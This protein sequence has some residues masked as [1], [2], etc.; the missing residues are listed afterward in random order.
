[1]TK[2]EIIASVLKELKSLATEE[3][4]RSSEYVEDERD[5]IKHLQAVMR[6]AQLGADIRTCAD[7][8]DLK[9]EC[10]DTCHRFG[11][12]REMSPMVELKSGGYAW[13]CCAI[14]LALGREISVKLRRRDRR[15]GSAGYKP[16]AEFFGGK[17]IDDGK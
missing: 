7:F 3:G 5:V 4:M 10:C 2:G 17:Q 8:L 16:F 9:V 11:F 12:P 6:E 14:E 1:M 13:I 15:V